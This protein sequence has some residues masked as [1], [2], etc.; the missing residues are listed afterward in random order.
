MSPAQNRDLNIRQQGHAGRITLTRPDALNALTHDMALQMEAALL[1]WKDDDS[2]KLVLVDAEGDK[3]FCAGGDV[4]KL[5]QTGKEGNFDYGRRFWTDEYR[6]NALIAEYPKPYIAFMQGFVMGGGVGIACHGSHRI[7]CESTR[8]AM[9]ECIIGLVPD[10]GGNYLLANAPGQLGEFLSITG[11]RMGPDDAIHAGFADHIVTLDKWDDLKK[12]LCDSGNPS[13]ILNSAQ[14]PEA[15]ELAAINDE[16]NNVFNV[17]SV[18]DCV[19]SLESMHAPWAEKAL[20]IIRRGCPL[21]VACAFELVRMAGKVSSVR[22]V[23]KLEL[24]FTWRSMSQGEFLEGVRAQI[25]D[26]DRSP[27]WKTATLE[28]VTKKQVEDML[29]PLG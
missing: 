7:V 5:Y 18:I 2:I 1:E 11:E 12:S 22:E 3:A 4:E 24:R 26:K 8:I 28:E 16:I 29:A 9:P 14:Q 19:R 23:V 17:E 13:V 6:L 21:S 20:K 25:I 27:N 15:S 10:V